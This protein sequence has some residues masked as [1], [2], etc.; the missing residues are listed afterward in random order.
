MKIYL[1]LVGSVVA[2]VIW[3]VSL[4]ESQNFTRLWPTVISVVSLAGDFFFLAYTFKYLP[5]SLVYPVWV[6]LG[7][8]GVCLYGALMYAEPM[9]AL[10][11][12]CIGLIV[13][14]VVGLKVVSPT[15]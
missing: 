11:L 5:I 9:G 7:A 8:L 14:G 10:K 1:Y 2:E 4:K 12:V 13:L 3:A 15:P 6:G